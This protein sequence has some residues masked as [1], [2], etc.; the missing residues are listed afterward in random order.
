M[1]TKVPDTCTS[2][3][4]QDNL[5]VIAAN[6]TQTL[7]K[8]D[9]TD[10]ILDRLVQVV[11]GVAGKLGS[12]E[13]KLAQLEGEAAGNMRASTVIRGHVDKL[14]FMEPE[15]GGTHHKTKKPRVKASDLEF[16]KS[17]SD[18]KNKKKKKTDRKMGHSVK[19][20]LKNM[21]RN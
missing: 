18:S 21:H 10:T 20:F 4:A 8:K 15:S 1:A 2:E 12:I 14:L 17:D 5:I 11:D 13:T 3:A 16:I 6:E 19:M 9:S 7:Q